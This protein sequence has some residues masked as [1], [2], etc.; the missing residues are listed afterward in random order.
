MTQLSM[1]Y[2][3]FQRGLTWTECRESWESDRTAFL[4]E[5][6]AADILPQT[7]AVLEQKQAVRLAVYFNPHQMDSRLLLP[8]LGNTLDRINGTVAR[9]FSEDIF[10]SHFYPR[11]GR[12]LPM[13][14]VLSENGDMAASWGPRPASVSEK[15][16]AAPTHQW[17]TILSSW[18]KV[19]LDG[20]LDVSLA[21]FLERTLQG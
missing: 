20:L 18:D 13:V 2:R 15:L 9:Y 8:T 11:V 12:G 17:D 5:V 1:N 7:M 14:M 19:Q 6:Q 3:M 10:F 4:N 16:H 21:D